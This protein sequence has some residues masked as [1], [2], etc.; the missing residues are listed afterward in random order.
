[1]MKM[2]ELFSGKGF[3][4][5][6]QYVNT[7]FFRCRAGGEREGKREEKGGKGRKGKEKKEKKGERGEKKIKGAVPAGRR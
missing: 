1:M 2:F 3:N 7:A 6:T 5:F 4:S